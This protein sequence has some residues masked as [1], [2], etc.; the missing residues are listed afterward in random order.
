MNRRDILKS[1][2]LPAAAGAL[3]AGGIPQVAQ[4]QAPSDIRSSLAA[5][6]LI[7]EIKKRGTLR[8]AYGAFKPWAMRSKTGDYIGFEIDVAKELAKDLGVQFEGFPTAWDGIIPALLAGRFDVI[9]GGMSVTVARNL[10]VNFSNGYNDTGVGMFANKKLAAGWTKL[11]DFNKAE[12]T[13][14]ARRG[15]P[16][17]N[18]VGVVMPKATLRQFDEESPALQEVV[19]GRAHAMVGSLPLPAHS[20][21]RYPNELVLPFAGPYRREVSAFAVRKGD[22]D[23]LNVFNNWIMLKRD[24]TSFLADRNAYWFGTLDWEDQIQP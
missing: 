5:A 2:I 7:E 22:P 14:V 4:A 8:V 15:T 16:A 12:V 21:R 11:E 17:A 10:T 18:S 6:S 23:A 24:L 13:I 9:I 3:L 19:N 20:V 1:P